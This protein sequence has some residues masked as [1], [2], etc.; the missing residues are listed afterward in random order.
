MVD[1]PPIETMQSIKLSWASVSAFFVTFTGVCTSVSENI[2][3]INFLDYNLLNRF[4]LS[5]SREIKSY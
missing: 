2:T 5:N 4:E 3:L 1:P